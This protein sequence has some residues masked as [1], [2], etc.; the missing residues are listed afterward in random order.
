MNAHTLT[1]NLARFIKN[2]EIRFAV[3]HVTTRCNAKCVDRCNIWN[4]PPIDMSCRDVYLAL[5]VL[6]KNNFSVA[7]FTGGETGLYPNLVDAIQYAKHK[8]FV[9]SIT[10]NGS[11]SKNTLSQL[12]RTLDVLSV[13][14]DHYD[15]KTWDR[16]KHLP[17]IAKKAKETIRLAKAFGINLY[18][19]TFLNPAWTPEEVGKV[20]SYVN[21]ELEIPFA[22]SYPFISSNNGTYTVGGKLVASD[23]YLLNIKSLVSKVLELKT[24]GSNVATTTCYIKEVLRAY[25]GVPLK[26]PCKAGRTILTIDCRLNVFPCYKKDLL[27]NLKDYQNLNLQPVDSSMCDNRSCLINCFKEASENSRELFMWSYVEE[28]FSNPKFYLNIIR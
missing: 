11:I 4:S 20:V 1:V 23:D 21:D 7:Y 15:E 6:E 3:I 9:T 14:V 16:M 26:Y 19:V 10:T 2:R 22:F 28:F 12:S 13:S 8:G 18:A 25:D 27:F 5:D 17:G 24:K